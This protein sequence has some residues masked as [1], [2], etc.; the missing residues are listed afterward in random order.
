MTPYGCFWSLG[1]TS[2]SNRSSVADRHT[3]YVCTVYNWTVTL[4]YKSHYILPF[5]L[6]R[7]VRAGGAIMSAHNLY[8][9]LSNNRTNV[10]LT[11]ERCV[12]WVQRTVLLGGGGCCHVLVILWFRIRV[13]DA[14]AF[15][16]R[17]LPHWQRDSKIVIHFPLKANLF[18]M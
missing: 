17:V 1:L 12:R 8:L 11:R 10:N 9:A 4:M 7:K 2:T 18:K 14:K 13:S 15:S 16:T 3:C 5:S 6:F